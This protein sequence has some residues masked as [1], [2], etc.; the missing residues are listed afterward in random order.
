MK[1]TLRPIIIAT[2][3]LL[4]SANAQPPTAAFDYVSVD[5]VMATSDVQQAQAELGRSRLGLSGSLDIDP[6]LSYGGPVDEAAEFDFGVTTDLSFDY[7][8]DSAA[9]LGDEID[10]L[11]AESRLADRR[12]GDVERALLAHAELLRAAL[13][14]GIEQDDLAREQGSFAEVQVEV[15]AGD[16]TASVL[17]DARLDLESAQLALARA[18]Q[19]LASARSAAD[20]FGVGPNPSFAI[21]H[22]ALPDAAPEQT[23]DYRRLALALRRVDALGLQTGTFGVLENITL[24]ATY[25]TDDINAGFNAS[26]DRGRPGAGIDVG[27]DFPADDPTASWE[28]ELSL[29][30][31]IDDRTANDFTSAERNLAEA[32]VDLEAFLSDFSNDAI[33]ERQDA[34]FA[35]Q[36]LQLALRQLETDRTRLSE[37]A[38]TAE[39]LPTEVARL[40]QT[41]DQLRADRDAA[42]G[43]ERTRLDQQVRDADETLRDAEGDLRDAE[44]TQA[45][46]ERTL[47]R[48]Q[49]ALYREWSEYVRAVEDYL[50][51]VDGVWAVGE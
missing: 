39:S 38:A 28:I 10:L 40:R 26:V 3:T 20:R 34:E 15:E 2:I 30:L 11:N 36:D 21:L 27:Y 1:R 31:R 46:L 37:V 13:F 17:E 47:P 12:R 5:T 24:G 14:V 48:S 49:D 4:F 29:S 44:R 41:A 35:W 25:G 23:F 51:V 9:I 8:F 16:A 6:T 32:Q 43:D 33:R 7:R 19:R 50:A 22:F 42:Q 18:E 45:S